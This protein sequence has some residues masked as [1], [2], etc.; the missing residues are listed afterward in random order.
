V[1]HLLVQP[2]LQPLLLQPL[3]VGSAKMYKELK[4]A[5]RQL[6]QHMD[7]HQEQLQLFQAFWQDP[8]VQTT[9]LVLSF[10]FK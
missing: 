6:T 7:C 2:L 5:T 4:E 3:L 9:Y 1:L 10:L 8:Q